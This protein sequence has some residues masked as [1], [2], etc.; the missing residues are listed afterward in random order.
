MRIL[1]MLTRRLIYAVA[2]LLVSVLATLLIIRLLIMRPV[3]CMPQCTGMNLAGRSLQR[4][5]LA[6]ANFVEANLQRVDFSG[7]NLSEADF[8]GANLTDADLRNTDLRDAKLIG[9]DLTRAN[10]GGALLNGVDLGGAN[11]TAADLTAVDLT[12]TLLS[13]TSFVQAKLTD[14]KLTG[15]NLAGVEFRNASL[16]GVNLVGANLAGANLSSA[17]LSGALLVGAE[18]TGAWFNLANLTGADA[19]NADLTGSSLIGSQLTSANLEGS[20][21]RGAI[22]VGAHLDGAN[23]RAANL[24][25]VRIAPETL[26][27]RELH[28][29]PVLDE[30][31]DLQLSAIRQPASLSGV[32]FNAET[33]WPAGFRPSLAVLAPATTFLSQ[34]LALTG[35]LAL[36]DTVAVTGAVPPPD[37]IASTAI[38]TS[39]PMSA[40]EALALET[41]TAQH[42]KVNFFINAIRAVDSA[43][44]AYDIDFTLDF[45]WL[46]PALVAQAVEQVDPATLWNPYL[47][48]VNSQNFKILTQHYQN[49][50]EP[51]ANVRLTYHVTG[52]FFTPFDLRKFPF[53]E[54]IFSIAMES[55]EYDSDTILFD[56]VYLLEPAVPT[57]QAYRQAVAK[58]RYVAVN[59]APAEWKVETV[60]IAQGVRVL[61][62]DK[63]SWSQF[64]IDIVMARQALYYF[65][66]TLWVLALIMF[67]IWGALLVDEQALAMRLWLLFM[68]C[69]LTVAANALTGRILPQSGTFTFLDLYRIV[70][71]GLIFGVALAAVAVKLLYTF[72]WGVW[73]ARLNRTLTLAYPVLVVVINVALY[74]YVLG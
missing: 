73:G 11:L 67:L 32:Q 69:L 35:P 57:A 9:A 47:D 8:S 49:S 44:G 15:A 38:T 12:E 39:L 20:I 66:K 4:A 55:A 1:A 16:A 54:Q 59:A 61:P 27:I 24:A 22:M 34:T 31:N 68:L 14:V 50:L 28:L 71:Y 3:T 42:V 72:Q 65:W 53:D 5:Q 43:T 60:T 37:L 63:S 51:G 46:D 18:L 36:T 74:W 17:D 48:L 25:E 10:L 45:H 64:R 58:G 13:G 29:D 62:Y 21:L 6:N 2:F 26:T 33:H 7:A 40:G 41:T 56:F 52:T 19:R 23:L 70:C 30:L